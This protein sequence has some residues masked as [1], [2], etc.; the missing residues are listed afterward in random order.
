[1]RTLRLPV[2]C[3]SFRVALPE[4]RVEGQASEPF[5]ASASLNHMA[6]RTVNREIL[7]DSQNV[8]SA[9]SPE[10]TARSLPGPHE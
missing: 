6:F 7:L 9:S 4:G 5:I 10:Y 2:I 8:G 1:M 3:V